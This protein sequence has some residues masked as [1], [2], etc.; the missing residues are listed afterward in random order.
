MLIDHIGTVEGLAGSIPAAV[1]RH[2][3]VLDP[4]RRHIHPHYNHTPVS[5]PGPTSTKQAEVVWARN[6]RSSATSTYGADLRS[7]H[8]QELCR[9]SHLDV[10][11][12][13]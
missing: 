4:T 2:T 1:W 9:L 8:V 12:L 13:L 11:R 3:L 5:S 6:N 10:N 7:G